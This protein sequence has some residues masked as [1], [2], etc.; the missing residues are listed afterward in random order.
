MVMIHDIIQRKIEEL[1]DNIKSAVKNF[2]WPKKLTE[3]ARAHKLSIDQEDELYREIMLVI[4]G[5]SKPDELSNH[6][7]KHLGVLPEKVK[8]L[9]NDINSTVLSPIQKASFTS[10]NVQPHLTQKDTTVQFDPYLEPID[11][12]DFRGDLSGSGVHLVDEDE[13]RDS[14]DTHLHKEVAAILGGAT[15]HKEVANNET[16]E[17]PQTT[18]EKSTTSYNEEITH[19]DLEGISGH[20]TDTKILKQGDPLSAFVPE[21]TRAAT[22][23]DFGQGNYTPDHSHDKKIHLQGFA[24]A[25]ESHIYQKEQSSEPSLQDI[26]KD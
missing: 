15:E 2:P 21:E 14:V 1:P 10:T 13:S 8:S 18:L 17:E 11:H 12:D 22:G 20:R 25:V 7:Q 9:V 19:K 16:I 3:I 23:R 5:M 4:V 26:S 24:P 6:I